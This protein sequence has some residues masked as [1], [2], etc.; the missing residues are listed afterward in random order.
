M[1]KKRATAKKSTVAAA[2]RRGAK[3]TKFGQSAA[4]LIRWLG[5]QGADKAQVRKAMNAIGLKAV[6]DGTI[7]IQLH[8]NEN[9]PALPADVAAKLKQFAGLK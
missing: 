9:I 8:L 7:R 2:P 6:A 4:S 3:F 5:K 1:A